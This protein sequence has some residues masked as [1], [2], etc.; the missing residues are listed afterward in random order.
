MKWS[1]IKA[2]DLAK[3]VTKLDLEP[4]NA[5][6]ASHPSYWYYI[7]GRKHHRITLPNQHGGSGSVSTG[8]L[9]KIQNQLRLQTEQFEDLVE[10][11]LTAEEYEAIVR[12]K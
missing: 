2:K 10:C 4:T 11:P 9:K 5:K 1:N 6:R 3:I 12:S 7:D 8:F